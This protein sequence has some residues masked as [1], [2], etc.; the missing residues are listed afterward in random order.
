[1][2]HRKPIEPWAVDAIA[3]IRA[4]SALKREFALLQNRV[5]PETGGP[6]LPCV[7]PSPSTSLRSVVPTGERWM[8]AF[9]TTVSGMKRLKAANCAKVAGRPRC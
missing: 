2:I 3:Y 4:S 7:I 1:M 8:S 5:Y 9:R 6:Q